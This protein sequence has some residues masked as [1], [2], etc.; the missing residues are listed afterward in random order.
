MFDFQ[1]LGCQETSIFKSS[2]VR[3][4]GDVL[5]ALHQPAVWEPDGPAGLEGRCHSHDTLAT[6]QQVNMFTIQ[7]A[8]Q[9][10]VREVAVVYTCGYY[11]FLRNTFLSFFSK[12]KTIL[13]IFLKSRPFLTSSCFWY[14]FQKR[15][16]FYLC[17]I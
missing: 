15:F 16:K 13:I 12:I 10:H 2:G 3:F 7:V 11:F 9:W 8:L 14:G 5:R 6:R 1:I 4:R 17:N